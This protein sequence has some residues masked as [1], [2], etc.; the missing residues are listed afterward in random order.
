[1]CVGIG[2]SVWA[3]QEQTLSLAQIDH[4]LRRI[5][6]L[7]Q[8]VQKLREQVQFK[9][10]TQ[11]SSPATSFAA[12]TPIMRQPQNRETSVTDPGVKI[13]GYLFGDYYWMAT[14]HDSNL[15]DRNGFWVRR[16]YLT[17]D[18]ELSS[19][20]DMRLRFEMKSAGDFSSKSKLV[21]FIKDAYLRWKFADNHQAYFG[22]SPTATWTLVNGIWGYL[23]VERTLLPL[24][25]WGSSRDLGIALKG[26]LTANRK[27]RYH[28][29]LGNGSH[30][31]TETN[32]GK[33][34]QL[35]LSFHPTDP[36]TMQVYSDY[37]ALPMGAYRRTLQGFIALRRDW[38]RIGLQYAHQTRHGATD[39]ELDALSL[40]GAWNFSPNLSLFARYDRNFDPNPEGAEISYLPF[41][42]TVEST[43]FLGG[44][45]LEINRSL[46]LMPN[47][48]VI[49]YDKR[50]DGKRLTTDLIPRLTFLYNY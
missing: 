19:D 1:M 22:M 31:G 33:K 4:L 47:V 35:G 16:A 26:D 12:V 34:V 9:N 29:M 6:T 45:D 2:S 10:T 20:F 38:G 43:L 3:Q 36:V 44:I 40:W 46:H 50:K 28:F 14:H 48:E 11:E 49:R 7:E 13:S 39:L 23:A 37:E 15:E 18:K 17:L 30:T 25:R 21:P 5:E 24:Q 32:S 41:A 42:S 8:T 27:V